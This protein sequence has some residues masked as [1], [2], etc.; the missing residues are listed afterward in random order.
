[1]QPFSNT[2]FGTPV[3][4][5][6][7]DAAD[8]LRGVVERRASVGAGPTHFDVIH[9]SDNG[10]KNIGIANPWSEGRAAE[11]VGPG[12]GRWAGDRYARLPNDSTS[13][14]PART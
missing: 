8:H 14:T 12:D 6:Q 3:S 7:D 5:D 2:V 10:R 9:C 1:V 11:L 13:G 4:F